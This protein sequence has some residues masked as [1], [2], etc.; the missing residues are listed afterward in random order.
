MAREF[1]VQFNDV[2][3]DNADNLL[4]NTSVTS[5][6]LVGDNKFVSLDSAFRN[7]AELSYITGE[8]DLNEINDIDYLLYNTEK[9]ESIFLKNITEENITGINAFPYIR[10]ITLMG[11]SYNKMALQNII[12]I[13]EW[14]YEGFSYD[15]KVKENIFINEKEKDNIETIKIQDT[16][17]QKA[18]SIEIYGESYENLINGREEITLIEEL[19]LDYNGGDE[20]F[21][22][23]IELPVY[24]VEIKGNEQGLGEQ[25]TDGTYKIN[26]V[27]D[28]GYE[29]IWKEL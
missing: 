16:L 15:G 12:S 17:E 5:V 28:N 14:T 25:Q 1:N 13:Q 24:I 10:S 18:T 11:E 2:A 22:P 20:G 26:I 8:I 29:G 21:I 3:M 19:T 23:H 7:C 27:V 9:V 6:T 4:E